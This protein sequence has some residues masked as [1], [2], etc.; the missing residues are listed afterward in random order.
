MN[1]FNSG[2]NS[3]IKRVLDIISERRSWYDESI[4]PKIVRVEVASIDRHCAE[5]ARHTLDCIA[6]DVKNELQSEDSKEC[7]QK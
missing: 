4:F 3:A 7:V 5:M 6:R 2:F 1:D